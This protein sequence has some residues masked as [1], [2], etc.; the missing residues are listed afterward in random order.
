MRVQ[1]SVSLVIS[2][3]TAQKIKQFDHADSQQIK[4]VTDAFTHNNCGILTIA[5]AAT[6][7]IPFADVADARGM[8]LEVDGDCTVQVNGGAEDRLMKVDPAGGA[9]AKARMLTEEALTAA[10]VENT[11]TAVLKVIYAVWGD[12]SS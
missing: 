9:T 2:D 10:T 7:S 3:D 1:H 5:A 12:P 8:Y 11:G 4:T 6:E